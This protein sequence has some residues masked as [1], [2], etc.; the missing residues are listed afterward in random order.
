MPDPGLGPK[1]KLRLG[2]LKPWHI[3]R[4]ICFSCRHVANVSPAPMLARF[5][6]HQRL[7]DLDSR[8]A[9]QECGNRWGNSARVHEFNR[10][11]P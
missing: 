8:F 5:G 3:L 6:E 7:V 9:C 11:G 4:V 1:Y 2:D 10:T